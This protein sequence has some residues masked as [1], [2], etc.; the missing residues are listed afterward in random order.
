MCGFCDADRLANKVNVVLLDPL[1]ALGVTD[2]RVGMM[3]GINGLGTSGSVIT[4]V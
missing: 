2:I 1:L 3:D 4:L